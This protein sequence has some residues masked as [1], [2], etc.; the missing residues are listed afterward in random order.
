MTMAKVKFPRVIHVVW[1]APG[2]DDPYLAVREDG[3]GS[4]EDTQTMAIYQLVKVGKA[5]VTR[6]FKDK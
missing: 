4:V 1:E 5:V 2:N 3:V 6:E